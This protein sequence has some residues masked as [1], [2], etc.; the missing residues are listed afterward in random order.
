VD[1]TGAQQFV[2]DLSY[3]E[4]TANFKAAQERVN[5]LVN[6]KKRDWGERTVNAL[7]NKK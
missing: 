2:D 4:A 1:T 5:K 6:H 7:L 3:K